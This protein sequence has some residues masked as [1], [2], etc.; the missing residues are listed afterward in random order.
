M[1]VRLGF[2]VFWILFEPV[3]CILALWFLWLCVIETRSLR[4]GVDRRPRR[5][6]D[7][8]GRTR[9]PEA[10]GGPGRLKRPIRFTPIRDLST[11]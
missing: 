6:E 2:V 9:G 7:P 11:Y 10:S 3:L 8:K 1:H 4:E 5:P